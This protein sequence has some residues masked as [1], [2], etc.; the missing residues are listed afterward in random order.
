[1]TVQVIRKCIKADNSITDHSSKKPD[2]YFSSFNSWISTK[3]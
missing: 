2:A 3:L 1:M